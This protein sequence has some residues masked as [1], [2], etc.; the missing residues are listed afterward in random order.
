M[1]PNAQKASCCS[2]WARTLARGAASLLT[3]LARRAAGPTLLSVPVSAAILTRVA[4]AHPQQP[5]DEVA[6]LFVSGR[7]AHVPVLDRGRAVSVITRGDVAAGLARVGPQGTVA[8]APSHHVV[9]VT[10]SDSL[11]HV[12]AQL[13]ATP[14][15]IAV[16]IDHD[17]PVGVLT[18]Y[19]VAAYLDD[20]AR[21]T[22]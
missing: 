5:L 12:L 13:E 8:A 19:E 14:D 10:P 4:W 20:V 22:V 15:S 11:A 2:R 9:A 18:A 6:Q 1:S 3:S 16:V 7:V 17:Q 21:R